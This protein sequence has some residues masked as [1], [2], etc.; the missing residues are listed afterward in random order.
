MKLQQR[1]EADDLRAMQQQLSSLHVV[2]EQ[3][4]SEHE[5]QLERLR[6]QLHDTQADRDRLTQQID[7]AGREEEE[8]GQ[9]AAAIAQDVNRCVPVG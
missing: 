2:M 7:G 1:P 6:A 5:Q 8:E 9:R 3:T 4:S